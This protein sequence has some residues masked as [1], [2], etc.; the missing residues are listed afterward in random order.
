MS[1]LSSDTHPKIERMQIEF[2][3]RMPAWKKFTI[4]DG[5][6]ET[7]KTLAVSGIKQYHP[8]ATPNKSSACW[9]N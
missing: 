6:N 7:V 5:L 8:N 4:V 9:R 3:R 1:A 2:I